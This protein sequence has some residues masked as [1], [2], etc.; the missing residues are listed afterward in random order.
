[1]AEVQT[2]TSLVARQPIR[3]TDHLLPVPYGP[4][5]ARNL[6][7]FNGSAYVSGTSQTQTDSAIMNIRYIT[8]FVKTNTGRRY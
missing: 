2:G 7:N 5:S 6:M 4:T 3:T 8:C 1:M